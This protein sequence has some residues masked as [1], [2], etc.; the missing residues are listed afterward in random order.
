MVS[1][2]ACHLDAVETFDWVGVAM[3]VGVA[4]ATDS[5]YKEVSCDLLARVVNFV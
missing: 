3:E 2:V 4:A 1:G 5:P